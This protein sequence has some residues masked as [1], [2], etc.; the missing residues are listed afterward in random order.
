MEKETEQDFE[1]EKLEKEFIDL[2]N[3]NYPKTAPKILEAYEFAK[4]AHD[5]VKRKSGEPYIVHPLCVAKI[6]IENNMDYATIIAGLLHDVVEDTD[7][8]LVDIKKRFGATVAKLVDGVT[9][10]SALQLKEKNLTEAD[11]MK[12]LLIAMGNDVRVIF[13]KLADRLHNMRTIEYLKPDRQVRMSKETKE[14]FIPIAERIGIRNIRSELQNLVLKCLRPEEYER[15][16]NEYEKKFAEK[17]E[18]FQK[19][20]NDIKKIMKDSNIEAEVSGWPEHIY[21][22]FKKLNSEGIAKIRGIY[23]FKII[24]PTELD[25][26]KTIGILHKHYSPLPGQIKDYIA[27]PKANGYS[28]LHSIL[29]A[30]EE[31][32]NFQVMVRTKEMDLVCEN[33]IASLWND[34]DSDVMFSESIEKYNNLKDIIMNENSELTNTSIF[35]DAI[36]TDLDSNT[37]WVFTPKFKPI[38]LNANKPTAIDFAYAVHSNI[39]DNAVGAII[40]GKKSSLG[41]E[42]E[43][44]DVVE[45]IV[46]DKKKAPSR[47]WLS[48]VKTASARKKIREY[49]SKNTTEKN[50][51]LGKQKLEAELKKSGHTL[52]DII[53]CYDDIQKEFNF[54]NLNDMYASIGYGGVTVNQV[55]RFA[56][57]KEEQLRLE[58]EG[59]VIVDSIVK[60]ANMSFPK[61]CSAIPGDKIVGVLAKNSVA[62]HTEDCRNLKR[63]PKE[64]I[65]KASWRENLNKK[66]TVSLKIIAKDTVGVAAELLGQISK[67]NYNLTKTIIRKNGL[68]ECE[69]EI[70]IQV[71]DTAELDE[72]VKKIT[73][74]KLVKQVVRCQE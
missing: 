22:I 65:V 56:T 49:F 31:N 52:S 57:L 43:S 54:I 67:L 4:N 13:I 41:A 10:I 59:P 19:I 5:G 39:G 30:R 7:I 33:G 45:I 11:S 23:F 2:V 27:S 40:N 32:V 24:V 9:K 28:S 35:I 15:I 70:S 72:F 37:V 18:R 46:S 12:R 36:K 47:D 44:G 66:F 74:L 64:Q 25:C 62:I 8:T 20:Q 69:F 71:K 17:K 29:V 58:K 6:L 60:F 38:C 50:I 16:K 55:A 26:Y 68:D 63:I 73:K 34:K 1:F 61:C 51:N 53:S 3:K 42:L 48:V 21:S 14:I